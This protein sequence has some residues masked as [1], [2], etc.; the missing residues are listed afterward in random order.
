MLRGHEIGL[1]GQVSSS[2]AC[3][4]CMLSPE[5]FANCYMALQEGAVFSHRITAGFI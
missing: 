4:K 2:L 5:E 1:P 3:I